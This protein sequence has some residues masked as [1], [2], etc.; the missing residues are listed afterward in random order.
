V[1]LPGLRL[2]TVWHIGRQTVGIVTETPTAVSEFMEPTEPTESVAWVRNCL[3]EVQESSRPKTAEDERHETV[4]T[5]ETAW[6]FMPANADGL[7]PAFDAATDGNPLSPVDSVTV[8]SSKVLRYAGRDYQM[9]GD[10]VLEID[11]NGH[12]DHVFA[13]CERQQ[14]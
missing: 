11:I 13:L 5:N 7:I 8:T 3:F 1:V 4:V 14:G 2:L 9:R 12:P 10:A 6:V